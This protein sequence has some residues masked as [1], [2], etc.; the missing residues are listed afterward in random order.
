MRFIPDFVGKPEERGHLRDL[1]IDG[2]GK[3]I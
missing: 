3:I 1:G 2:V